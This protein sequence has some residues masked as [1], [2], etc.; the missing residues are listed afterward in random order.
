MHS[1]YRTHT[2]DTRYDPSGGVVLRSIYEYITH[3]FHGLRRIYLVNV[4]VNALRSTWVGYRVRMRK[5]AKKVIRD[6]CRNKE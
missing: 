4:M 2:H 6:K 3:M 5:R 1:T